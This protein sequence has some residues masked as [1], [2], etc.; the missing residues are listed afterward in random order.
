MTCNEVDSSPVQGT[1]LAFVGLTLGK[2]TATAGECVQAAVTVQPDKQGQ[3]VQLEQQGGKGWAPVRTL[4]LGSS[5][6]A[7]G[8][9]VTCRVWVGRSGRVGVSDRSFIAGSTT[10]CGVAAVICRT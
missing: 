5:S 9:T 2:T 7:C 6:S 3:H 4:T 8:T 1:V 10:V